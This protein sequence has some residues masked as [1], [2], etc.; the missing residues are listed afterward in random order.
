M[1]DYSWVEG[2][3]IDIDSSLEDHY[4]HYTRDLSSPTDWTTPEELSFSSLL[5]EDPKSPQK[6]NKDPS[7]R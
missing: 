3:D 6:S 5:L 2:E 1:G 7:V 4:T